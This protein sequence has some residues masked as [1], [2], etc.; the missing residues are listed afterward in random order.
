V[1]PTAALSEAEGLVEN[2]A[3][4][5]DPEFVTLSPVAGTIA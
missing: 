5:S 4:A 2:P 3:S 1:P